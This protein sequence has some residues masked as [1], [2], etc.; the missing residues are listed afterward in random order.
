[1]VLRYTPEDLGRQNSQIN[2]THDGIGSPA[3]VLL[4]GAGESP[5]IDTA[6][7]SIASASGSPGDIIE[8][9]VYISYHDNPIILKI[10]V[11]TFLQGG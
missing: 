11:Q 7:I 3:K 8:I 4:F 6:T 1:M 9:P 5:S 2:F 10:M